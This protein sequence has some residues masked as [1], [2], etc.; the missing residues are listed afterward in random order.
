MYG[1]IFVFFG[2]IFVFLKLSVLKIQKVYFQISKKIVYKQTKITYFLR[3]FEN[4][5][6]ICDFRA[7]FKKKL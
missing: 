3:I 5:Q 4:T 6:E 1:D 2:I 7:I